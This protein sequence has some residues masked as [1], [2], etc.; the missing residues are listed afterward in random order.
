[1]LYTSKF[2]LKRLAPGGERE[3]ERRRRGAFLCK[4]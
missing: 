1:M 2:A 4:Y 3:R